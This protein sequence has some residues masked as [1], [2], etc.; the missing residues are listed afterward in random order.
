VVD[1]SVRTLLVSLVYDQSTTE[2]QTSTI[3]NR[4]PLSSTGSAE[5]SA[6]SSSSSCINTRLDARRRQLSISDARR[7]QDGSEVVVDGRLEGRERVGHP[8]PLTQSRR[9]C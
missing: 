2:S 4:P 1:R 6:G 9:G 5:G 8:A 3:Q 7:V